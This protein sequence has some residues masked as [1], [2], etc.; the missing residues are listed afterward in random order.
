[1]ITTSRC[2]RRNIRMKHQINT[3]RGQLHGLS[4]QTI[5]VRRRALELGEDLNVG[6]LHRAALEAELTSAR[7]RLGRV[8]RLVRW[9]F[10]AL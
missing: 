1:M 4:N 8:P 2:S 9:L 6:L 3:L 5:N 7:V 10:K